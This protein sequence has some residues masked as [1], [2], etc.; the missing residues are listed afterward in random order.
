V[1]HLEHISHLTP[2]AGRLGFCVIG[3]WPV[4]S[5][6]FIATEFLSSHVMDRPEPAIQK[7]GNDAGPSI[8]S[9]IPL[10]RFDHFLKHNQKQ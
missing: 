9:K 6:I 8:I 1:H 3:L 7:S 5:K 4:N 10:N 2:V